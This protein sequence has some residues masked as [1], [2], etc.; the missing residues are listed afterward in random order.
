MVVLIVSVFLMAYF[1]IM[2][3]IKDIQKISDAIVKEK[4][5]LEIKYQ[6]GQLLKEI[7]KDFEKIKPQKNKLNTIFLQKGEELKFVTTLEEIA[8]KY[9]VDQIIVLNQDGVK[10]SEETYTLPINIEASGEFI[11]VLKYLYDI[12]KLSYYFNIEMI[13]VSSKS[14][15]I[16]TVKVSFTGDIFSKDSDQNSNEIIEENLNN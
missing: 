15:N 5:D 9:N 2:P 10:K 13:N 14:A 8:K 7:S 1:I 12:E 4:E 6:K 11:Q 16:G 3:T